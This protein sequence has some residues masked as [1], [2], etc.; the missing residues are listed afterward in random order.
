VTPRQ[1]RV[2]RNENATLE[3]STP[4]RLLSAFLV[5]ALIVCGARAQAEACRDDAVRMLASTLLEF[6][7][8][9]APLQ[10]QDLQR[11]LADSRTTHAERAIA[12]ALLRVIHTPDPVDIEPLLHIVSDVSEPEEIRQLAGIVSHLVHTPSERDRAQLMRLL[13]NLDES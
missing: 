7:H 10:R 2:A 3:E 1:R 6:V 4:L 11:L 13:E 9:C 5:A 8:T 12:A